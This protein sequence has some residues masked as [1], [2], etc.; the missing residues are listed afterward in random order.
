M[1]KIF[2]FLAVLFP[3]FSLCQTE[4]YFQQRADFSIDVK[5]NT[6]DKTLDGFVSLD[7]TN[8][9]PDTLH[10]IWFHLWPNA[11]KNDQTAF[12]E[13]MLQLGNTSFYFCDESQRGYINKLN[14][15]VDGKNAVLEDH[16]LY[17]DVAKLI[18]P[19]AL[20]P[21]KTIS[22]Q[23]P[24]HEKLSYL[25]SRGG[26]AN[27][28]F[29]ITQWYPKPAVYDRKGWHPMPYLEQGEFY[30]EFGDYKVNITLPSEY[31]IAATGIRINSQT[32]GK[33]TTVTYTQQNIHDF[34][35]FAGKE[36]KVDSN[37][38]RSSDGRTIKLFSYY[39]PK[40]SGI[41]KNSLKYIEET[42]KNREFNLGP[43]PYSTITVVE[44][45]PVF[46]GGME[47]P[48]IASI[49]PADDDETLNELINHEVGHNWT[50]GALANNERN[51]PWM[52]EG[53][54]SFYT[55]HF[56]SRKYRENLLKTRKNFIEKRLP[57]NFDKFV[58]RYQIAQK[59]DQPINLPS[60]DFSGDN[61]YAI[62]YYKAPLWMHR[63]KDY[64]GEDVFLKCMRKYYQEWK[65]KHPYPE[66][67]KHVIAKTSGRNV[68]SIFNLLNTKGKILPTETKQFKIQ[69][70]DDF[71]ESQKYNYLFLSPAIGVNHYDN[72]MAGILIHNY[73][74][75]EPPF[76]FFI[77]PMFG[78]GSK[79][80]VGIG[81]IGYTLNTYGKI[82]KFE[83]S[84]SGAHFNMRE[85][86]D[87]TGK[88]NF[89]SFSKIVPA[90]RI[91]FKNK[92]PLSHA[93][94]Y[95]Q[96]KT[97]LISETSLMFMRDT[98]KGIDV[99]T[100]PK[101]ERYLNELSFTNENNRALYPF[102]YQAMI[103]QGNGFARLTLDLNQFFNYPKGGG[104]NARLFG[105]K[106]MYS[107]N[108]GPKYLYSRYQFNMTG[109]NGYEDYTYSNYFMG[110]NQYEGLSSQQIMLR[111]GGFKIRTDLLNNK[112]GTS[113]NWLAALNLS[114]DI[115]RDVNPL[116]ILPG[117]ITLKAFL[118]IGTYSGG[119][120]KDAET[121]KFL[122][123]AGLQ[124]NLIKD[125]VKIY[126]PILYSKVYRDYYKSTVEK[127]KR[128]WKTISFSID[129]Q[130]FRLRKFLNL[131]E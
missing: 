9:S 73:T 41:W 6:A 28:F 117:I 49:E 10:F 32:S 2:S 59:K 7:Y 24:F 121:G 89:M 3:F 98:V 95:L 35:W 69:S 33:T 44:A 4:P 16:P 22:I 43:Y 107:D 56:I 97:Y 52:D 72:F 124:I 131:S 14:F 106:L 86:T 5:L 54:T 53:M 82:R 96:W 116:S 58:Y 110:R 127:E 126:I 25:F 68:D 51:Y 122:Y 55:D 65:F 85:Y 57:V 26:Y 92:S 76:H 42:V 12:S 61:Y 38:I 123:D 79:K 94:K 129:I 31:Q 30:S 46:S 29:M 45:P 21:G 125:L 36:M 93:Y 17:I 75:P 11:Y 19:E 66:D 91:T 60:Q 118:D 74:L 108:A 113:D 1:K 104:L 101:K 20:P 67:F 15:A 83:P 114:T 34:A 8:N 77:A 130:Q 23:T 100:Y 40:D 39:H 115:P 18:L 13:Q 105:G 103:Q 84:L 128:F 50:Y 102:S 109:P 71:S 119:W 27:D 37:E 87:S 48:T 88:K 78:T 99:I 64:L 63:L 111:D 62:I 120:M 90:M 70:F 80:L 112:V 81:R 47:Y